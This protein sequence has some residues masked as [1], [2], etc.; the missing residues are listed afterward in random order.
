MLRLFYLALLRL[1][2]K[3][4]RERF[5]DEMQLTFEE[6]RKTEGSGRLLLD[7]VLSLFRQALLR[8]HSKERLASQKAVQT[9]ADA[10]FL[11][12]PS[13][14]PLSLYRF[15]QGGLISAAL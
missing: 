15:F 1:H 3:Q 4:F 7:G 12:T 14:S 8:S 2:P 11:S 9:C 10:C 5:A 6:A 13:P